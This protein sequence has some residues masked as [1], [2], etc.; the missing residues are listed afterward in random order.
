MISWQDF[1][2][3]DINKYLKLVHVNLELL[4]FQVFVFCERYQSAARVF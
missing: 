1:S 3:Y 4:K 2:Y